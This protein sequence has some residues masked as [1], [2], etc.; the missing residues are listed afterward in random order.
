M[1][2]TV[3]T[4]N[5]EDLEL[6]PENPRLPRH[7]RRDQDQMLEFLAR[8]S[9]IDELMSAIAENGFFGGETLIAVKRG[10]KYVVVEGNRRLT[11]LRLLQG[12]EYEGISKRVCEI[13]DAAKN[14]PSS[15]PVSVYESRNEVLNYL[16]NRHIAGVKQWGALAK[17]RYIQ[18]LFNE[19]GEKLSF[20]ERC[21]LV[22]KT[23]G[24][25]SNFISKSMRAMKLYDIA[26]N[27]DFFDHE[28]LDED[29]VKFSLLSTAVDYEGIKTFLYNAAPEDEPEDDA[30]PDFDHLKQLFEWM[31]VKNGDRPA[32]GE[33]RNIS[34]L[35]KVL[36]HSNALKEFEN[37][38]TLEQ[39]Y[40]LTEGVNEDFDKTLYDIQNGL[41]D[42]NSL[43]ADVDK[44]DRR[45]DLVQSVFRQAKTLNRSMED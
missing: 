7:V 39:A 18:M 35:S 4:L 41:R 37:G 25:R 17:A 11:A 21:R 22:A 28:E 13:R 32:L 14:K 10:N 26:E 45:I 40:L 1:S 42:A 38:A 23:I 19:T 31:F 29:K 24:S 43:V 34:K 44:T 2:Y 36:L 20:S 30:E 5:I 15:V 8:S 33:S 3:E 16:G 9:S 27:S 6:D 12:K